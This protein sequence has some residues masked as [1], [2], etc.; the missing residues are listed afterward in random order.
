[1]FGL[2]IATLPNNFVFVEQ[3]NGKC[4]LETLESLLA[5]MRLSRDE[6]KLGRDENSKLSR[7]VIEIQVC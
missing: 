3:E 6:F 7:E 4:Q 5:E 1:M 2:Q